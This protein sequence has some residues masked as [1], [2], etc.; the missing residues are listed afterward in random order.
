VVI[1]SA[2][3]LIVLTWVR[4]SASPRQGQRARTRRSSEWL[5]RKLGQ[6][7]ATGAGRSIPDRRSLLARPRLCTTSSKPRAAWEANISYHHDQASPACSATAHRDRQGWPIRSFACIRRHTVHGGRRGAEDLEHCRRKD[8]KHRHLR[9]V[10]LP[11]RRS[12]RT[13]TV[14]TRRCRAGAGASG[15]RGRA[16]RTSQRILRLPSDRCRGRTQMLV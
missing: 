1:A 11:S 3:T 9:H 6:A 16:R 2:F 10:V 7:P 12:L 13:T 15:W 5:V 4:G 8:W 14:K